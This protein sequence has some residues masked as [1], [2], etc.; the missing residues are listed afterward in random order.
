MVRGEL[1]QDWAEKALCFSDKRR[2]FSKNTSLSVIKD[3]LPNP[4]EYF[5]VDA[6]EIYDFGD[7]QFNHGLH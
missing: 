2:T 4:V 7:H 3:S 5:L 6:K 1:H